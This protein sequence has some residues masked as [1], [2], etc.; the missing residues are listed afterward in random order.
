M[1]SYGICRAVGVVAWPH[2][3]SDDDDNNYDDLISIN[4]DR[5]IEDKDTPD[6]REDSDGD[7]NDDDQED[8][9][10][11]ERPNPSAATTNK[12]SLYVIVGENDML[13]ALGPRN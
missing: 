9:I 4:N 2:A 8:S 10:T 5:Y 7:N 12:T 1:F 13:A 6:A 3:A 11:P